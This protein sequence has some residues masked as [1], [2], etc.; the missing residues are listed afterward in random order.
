M[1]MNIFVNASTVGNPLNYVSH[2]G[3]AHSMRIAF[4]DKDSRIP[5]Y[6]TFGT[7]IVI[8]HYVGEVIAKDHCRL[9]SNSDIFTPQGST[10]L[11]VIWD[12]S[13]KSINDSQVE[14]TNLVIIHPTEEFLR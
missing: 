11:Q 12:L 7:S 2:R 10:K 5:V 1:Q 9:V 8:Q 3:N 14:F 6:T 13:V 4:R